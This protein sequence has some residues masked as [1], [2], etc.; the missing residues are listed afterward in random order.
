[1]KEIGEKAG[2][3]RKVRKVRY[4]DGEINIEYVPFYKIL[5]THIARKSY[6][7]NSLI[8]DIPERIVRSISKHKNERSFKRYVEISE[9]YKN[10]KIREVFEKI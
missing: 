10:Q 1:L 7:T 3:T 9:E 2:L 6:I 5:T 8:L 4:Y